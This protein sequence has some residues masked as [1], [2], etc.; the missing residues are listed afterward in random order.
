[1]STRKAGAKP[2]RIRMWILTA[3]EAA[4]VVPARGLDSKCGPSKNRRGYIRI[5]GHSLA[6]RLQTTS[7]QSF[8]ASLVNFRGFHMLQDRVGM[9]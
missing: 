4:R 9:R 8:N 5:V 6:S 3:Q 1:M 2:N 7:S